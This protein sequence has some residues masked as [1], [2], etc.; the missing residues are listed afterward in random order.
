MK[1]I[2]KLVGAVCAILVA[3]AFFGG[4][5]VWTHIRLNNLANETAT[6]TGDMNQRILP[7]IQKRF[8]ALEGAKPEDKK[9]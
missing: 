7:G 8:E 2:V 1:E 9:K 4:V 5:T 6:I 3:G